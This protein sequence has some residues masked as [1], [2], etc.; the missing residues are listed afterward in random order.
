M[1]MRGTPYYYNGDEL[2]MTNIR[3]TKIEDYRDMSVLNEYQH[4]KDIKGDIPK[5]MQTISF[6]CRDNGRTPF[7]WD[8]SFNAGFTK[9]TPWI[10]VNPNYTTINAAAQEKDPN[11]CLNYFRKLTALRKA[12][13]ALIYGK[14]TLLDKDNPN[15]YTY[16]REW[17]GKKLLVVLNFT[18]KTVGTNTGVDVSKAKILLSNYAGNNNITNLRPYEAVIYEL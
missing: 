2:G 17:E 12:N 15:A 9:G 10:K 1:S 13:S 14:Y 18:S 7:Q 8:S 4:Q 16:L 6:S 5:F 11:S 3:F